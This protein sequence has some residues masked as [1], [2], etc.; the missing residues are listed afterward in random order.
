[1]QINN[2]VQI[3]GLR[4]LI[5]KYYALVLMF[6]IHFAVNNIKILN[7]DC[8]SA[9]LLTYITNILCNDPINITLEQSSDHTKEYIDL[10]EIQDTQLLESA[11]KLGKLTFNNTITLTHVNKYYTVCA[12][13][14]ITNKSHYIPVIIK[15]TR[16]KE[17]NK[18][19]A[20]FKTPFSIL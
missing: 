5:G 14:C 13:S 1:M 18:S 17:S 2:I 4:V 12:K 6:Y 3:L 20:H 10:V 15:E 9:R 8:L 11:L 19:T 16:N 7:E